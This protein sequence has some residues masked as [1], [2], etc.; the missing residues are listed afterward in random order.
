LKG[1]DSH[2]ICYYG[3]ITILEQCEL[4]E[5]IIRNAIVWHQPFSYYLLIHMPYIY[6]YI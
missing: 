2:N 4:E 3:D 5:M 6:T 1:H